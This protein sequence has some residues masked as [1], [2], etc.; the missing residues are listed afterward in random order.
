MYQSC[1]RG[2]PRHIRE[3]E[4][5]RKKMGEWK[6]LVREK[7]EGGGGR[8]HYFASEQAVFRPKHAPSRWSSPDDIQ[9]HM[10]RGSVAS[11]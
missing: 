10:A 2:L 5:G 1:P 11:L 9:N 4:Q 6:G 3:D 7:W 8:K